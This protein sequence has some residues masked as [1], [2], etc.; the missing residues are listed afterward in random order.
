MVNVG[1]VF[2]CSLMGCA[3][4]DGVFLWKGIGVFLW[5]GIGVFL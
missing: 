5:K 3:D 2:D 4:D 1:I